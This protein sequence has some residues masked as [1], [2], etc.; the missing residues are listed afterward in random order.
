MN[1]IDDICIKTVPKHT[2]NQGFLVAFDAATDFRV[3][4]RRVF[5]VSGLIGAV[6]GRHA[7]R[8]LTQILVCLHGACRIICDD[9]G[10]RQE[11][12]L[13]SPEI[14]LQVPPGIWAEQHYA[15]PDTILMVL[16]DMPFDEEDYIRDYEEFIAFRRGGQA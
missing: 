15:E 12:L 4:F 7:H 9:G 6:R 13:N 2:D 1:S 16:C 10:K 5:V 3:D 8:E 11:V 14:A